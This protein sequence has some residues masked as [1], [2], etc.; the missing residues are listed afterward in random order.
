MKKTLSLLTGFF[1]IFMLAACNQTADPV[2]NSEKNK[3]EATNTTEKTSKLTLEEV[4]EKS[5]TASESLKS[6]SVKM[7]MSQN[8]SSDQDDM[9]MDTHS[10]IDMDVVTEP[11]AFYQKMKMSMGEETFETESYFSEEG[12]F[13][14]EPSNGQW[15][16][17]PQDMTDA[18][19]QMS[20]QQQNPGEELKKL[21]KFVDDFTFEQ[22]EK[23]FILKLK[24]SGDKF[25][26]FIKEAAVEALPPEMAQED[27]LSGMKVNAMEYEILIDKETFNPVAI[28]MDMDMEMTIENQTIKMK[29][30]MNGQYSNLNKVEKITVPQNVVDSA[31]E[32]DM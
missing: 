22:D 20:G 21:Q 25:N 2:S 18:F 1:L 26:D 15:M 29:Q 16:K 10:V 19:M 7:D 11:M 31:V 17:F 32:M 4:L 3:E 12:M 27:L 5:T 6:F 8:I 28:I 23:N 14:Y 24:A 13:F 30:K 9:N